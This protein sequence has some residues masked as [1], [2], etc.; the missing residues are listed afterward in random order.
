M[1]ISFKHKGLEK[2]YLTGS[3]AGIQANHAAKLSRILARLEVAKIPQ[4]MNIPGWNLHSL[5]GN[6]AQHWSVKVNG[7]WRVTFKLENGHTE[8]VDYQDYH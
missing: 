3:K 8:I 7:N 2:F 5:T 6:L 1:I 4:D